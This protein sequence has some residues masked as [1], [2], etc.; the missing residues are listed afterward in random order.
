MKRMDGEPVWIRDATGGHWELSTDADDYIEGREVDFYG[1]TCGS[2]NCSH[3]CKYGLHQLGWL[4]YKH[5][6]KGE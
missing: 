6:P 5:K 2:K 4:A 1:L 3:G